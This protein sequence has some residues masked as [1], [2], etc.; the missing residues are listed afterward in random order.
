MSTRII[1]VTGAT[2]SQGGGLAQAI[3]DHGPGEHGFTLRAITRNPSS[4]KAR[5]LAEAGAQVVSADLN[6][7]AS[8]TA[9]F[10]GAYGAYCVTNFWEHMDPAVEDTQARHLA[11]A[12][13]NAGLQHVIWSTLE[14]TRLQ[15]RLD[16]DRMP[17]LLGKY[18]VP[19]F[20]VKGE[21]DQYFRDLG[22][23]TTFLHPPFYWDN[24]LT[25]FAPTA[26]PDGRLTLT[27]PM[28]DRKL[29]G[30]A[31][32]DIGRCAYGVFERGGDFIGKSIG[33]AGEQLTGDEM[34]AAMSRVLDRDITYRAITPE[35]FRASGA[36]G[37]ADLGN[38]F[39]YYAD[40]ETEFCASHDPAFARSINPALQ[41]FET[42]L[43]GSATQL[44]LT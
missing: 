19:H 4:P 29:A 42:W 31:A 3:L 17:T 38:M 39:A 24:L 41:T 16:D 11:Q 36:P 26:G 12:A 44:T 43:A 14:D 7:P 37:A 20:D 1:A 6:D 8:L 33:I 15:V 28:G 30:I 22:V 9:A 32:V 10:D 40:F 27:L 5:A 18:K 21:A 35:A 25:T 23:P 2:G 34:A 13:K